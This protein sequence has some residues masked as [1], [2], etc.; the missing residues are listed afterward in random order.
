MHSLL[1]TIRSQATFDKALQ[2]FS[3]FTIILPPTLLLINAPYGRFT[4][5]NVILGFGFNKT[6]SKFGWF[7]MEI[8]SPIMFATML[9]VCR[10][11]LTSGQ[12]CMSALWFIHYTNRTFIYTYR[13]P[14]MA[15]I[16]FLTWIVAIGFNLVNAYINGYWVATH[17]DFRF[18]LATLVGGC[19]WCTGFISN[20]YHDSILFD[21]RKKSDGYSIPNGGLFKYVSCP[22]YFSECV[23]WIGFAL[24]CRSA[25]SLWFALGTMSNLIPRA[26]KSHQ[27]YKNRFKNYPSDRKAVIP[28]LL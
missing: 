23:E 13:V 11:P 1:D 6:W 4:S 21:L 16:G 25:P 18:D 19:V 15:P 10:V 28:F 20:I 12:W 17:D 7:S 14:S 22:N 8:V 9:Y 3:H 2:I 24:V 27:W 26:Y 5:K